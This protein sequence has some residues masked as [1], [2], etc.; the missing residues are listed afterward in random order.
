[1]ASAGMDAQYNNSLAALEQDKQNEIASTA[2]AIQA[3]R[4]YLGGI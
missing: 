2:L 3:L 1:M 4:P